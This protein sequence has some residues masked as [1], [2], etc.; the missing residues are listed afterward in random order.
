MLYTLRTRYTYDV[1]C[2]AISLASTHPYGLCRSPY[3]GDYLDHAFC[4][5][6]LTEGGHR[7]L[8]LVHTVFICV[9][10]WIYLVENFGDV[11]KADHIFW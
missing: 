8:D 5:F 3:C 6:N 11:A 4:E 10:N 2:V 9:A 1:W 7:T